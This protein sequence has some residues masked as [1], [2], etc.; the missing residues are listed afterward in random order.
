MVS[1]DSLVTAEAAVTVPKGMPAFFERPTDFLVE[2]VFEEHGASVRH[3]LAGRLGRP[4]VADP[5]CVACLL[6][7]HPE[8]EHVYDD[9]H[10]PLGLHRT[11]HD[12]EAHERLTVFHHERRNDRVKGALAGL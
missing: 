8:V 2:P 5:G 11:S 1:Q 4:A 12:A 3:D 9:L 10:V 7:I 6:Q